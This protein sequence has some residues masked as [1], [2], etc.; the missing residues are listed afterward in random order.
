MPCIGRI[1]SYGLYHNVDYVVG[2]RNS[3]HT[4]TFDRHGL[5]A[6]SFRVGGVHLPSF[7]TVDGFLS[8]A[9]PN[10]FE[11]AG[12]VSCVRT[13]IL[14]LQRWCVLRAVSLDT[15]VTPPMIC[16]MFR[17]LC[18]ALCKV[19]GETRGALL[20]LLRDAATPASSSPRLESDDDSAVASDS[21]VF[22]LVQQLAPALYC[23]ALGPDY[24]ELVRLE[25]T[26]CV[27]E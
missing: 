23:N 3:S 18:D 5:A 8:F 7:M 2:K 12:V 9:D 25:R 1:C 26:N 19:G 20:Q 11:A 15:L 6:T 21:D 13:T 16:G 17:P 14:R 27:L 24:R 22:S 10:R 4:I